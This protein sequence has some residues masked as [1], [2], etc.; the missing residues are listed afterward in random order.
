MVRKGTGWVWLALVAWVF[1]CS[2]PVLG[3]DPAYYARKGTW[4]DTVCALREAMA[5]EEAEAAKA[6]A[7]APKPGVPQLSVWHVI[8][9][10]H[11]PNAGFSA[12]YPPEQE[13]ALSKS[14]GNLRWQQRPEFADGVVHGLQA[15]SQADTYLYRTITVAAPTTLTGYF[16][17]DDG[18]VVWLNGKK[19]ISKDVPRGPSPNQDSA[20]LA[21]RRGRTRCC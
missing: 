10:F 3:A 13:I 15:P 9:P 7:E 6:R 12:V 1:V 16:G 8:G 14:Y 2:A 19:L 21:S 11:G 5:K 18:L 17:S 20:K 4:Q